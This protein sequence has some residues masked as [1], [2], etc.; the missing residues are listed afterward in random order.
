M[1]HSF[2][3][4]ETE[5]IWSGRRSRKLPSDIQKRARDKLVLLDAADQLDDLLNP[6]SNKLHPLQNDR[7]G[8]HAIWINRQWRIC[9]SWKG[10]HAH[11]VEI[12]DY[13]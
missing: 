9:F 4:K 3:D 12:T 2:A 8:Q 1:I 5:L 13:H 7:A 6:P 11:D 10:G